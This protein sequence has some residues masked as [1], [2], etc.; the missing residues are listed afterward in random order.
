MYQY[1]PTGRMNV[2]SIK[3]KVGRPTYM[4][5]EQVWMAFTLLL[6]LMMIRLL[7]T[8]S[9]HSMF[10]SL[11]KGPSRFVVAV[12]LYFIHQAGELMVFENRELR[13]AIWI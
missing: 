3:E 5:T 13:G 4:K 7:D 8:S 12:V 6:Q 2:C 1:I 11:T 9:R 10:K